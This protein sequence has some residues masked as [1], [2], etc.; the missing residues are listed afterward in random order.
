M[1][2]SRSGSSAKRL[3]AI[4]LLRF[5]GD[6]IC[7][8][9]NFPRVRGALELMR[10]LDFSLGEVGGRPNIIKDSRLPQTTVV[11]AYPQYSRFRSILHAWDPNRLFRSELTDRLGL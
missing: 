4:Y 7:F 6:G 8:A 9:L 10:D 11:A 1:F 2:A 3:R 5:C